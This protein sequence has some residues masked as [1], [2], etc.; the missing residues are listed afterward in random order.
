MAIVLDFNTAAKQSVDLEGF[1]PPPINHYEAEQRFRDSITD[2][3]LLPGDISAS[4]GKMFRCAVAGDSGSEKSGWFVYF[5]DGIPSG[6]FGNWRTGVTENWSAKSEISMTREELAEHVEKNKK[7]RRI[8]QEEEIT[9]HAEAA[10]HAKMVWEKATP[11]ED[12]PYLRKKGVAS[13]GLR[14]YNGELLVPLSTPLGEMV[15]Y[16][17]ITA[18]GGK[19]YLA[20]GEKKACSFTIQ[21]KGKTAL[22]EG[23]ATAATIHEATG[24]T[25]IV[26]F[27]AG[28]LLS[29]AEAWRKKHPAEELIICADDDAFTPEENGGNRG[30]KEA[31]KVAATVS[32]TVLLPDFS[33]LQ[34]GKATDW[35]DLQELAGLDEVKRQFAV[36]T[37]SYRV[38]LTDWVLSD[39]DFLIRPEPRKHLVRALFPM[40]AVVLVAAVGGI[41][42]SMLMLDL[43]LKVARKNA[44]PEWAGLDFNKIEVFGNEILEHG[45]VVMFTAEDNADDVRERNYSLNQG[46]SFPRYPISI[47]PLPTACGPMPFILPGGK[48]GP[49]PSPWWFEAKQQLLDI[50]PKLIVFDPLASF[51][52]VDLNK[53]EVADFTMSLFASLADETGACVIVT[54]HLSK[55]KDNNITT[56]EQAR[57]LVRGSTA[58]VDRT[59]ATYVLWNATDAEGQEKCA[60]LGE[61]WKRNK[62]VKGC[63][64]KENFGGDQSIK[65]F[66]RNEI[67]L[68]M[69]RDS[70]LFAS[71]A[72]KAGVLEEA[73]V[74]AIAEAAESAQPFTKT[75][76]NG[77]FERRAELPAVLQNVGRRRLAPLVDKLLVEGRIVLA[78]PIGGTT[79]NRLDIPNGPIAAATHRIQPGASGGA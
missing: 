22:A 13:H 62:V 58:L 25:V 57:S 60:A 54:H 36:A 69:V 10:I 41:G 6:A 7:A 15:S 56:P 14:V 72:G 43:C 76:A 33:K 55:S 50:R 37:K 4:N 40:K 1:S 29:V 21:G 59:R 74:T 26:A 42:K 64:T 2:A 9:R 32:A 52:L 78:I 38:T 46:Q 30:V 3:G 27:D 66:V 79:K 17:R 31:E 44:A 47:I 28:N 35:N 24:W 12:F 67:G 20:G 61:S 77:L 11:V 19:W 5:P 53:P 51:A 75:G 34:R 65:T 63:L 8:R 71:E 45:P 49:Q 48:D 39:E 18:S 23:Y 73:L 68:L 16:Q 70:E